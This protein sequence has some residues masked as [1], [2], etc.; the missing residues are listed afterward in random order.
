MNLELQY[1]R[2]HICSIALQAVWMRMTKDIPHHRKGEPVPAALFEKHIRPDQPAINRIIDASLSFLATVTTF[3]NDGSMPYLPAHSYFRI[4][5]VSY[6]LMKVF[7]L[8]LSSKDARQ[9]LILIKQVAEALQLH[10]PDDTHVSTHIG[11]IL[12]TLAARVP[13]SLT[14]IRLDR[15]SSNGDTSNHNGLKDFANAQ[16]TYVSDQQ[17]AALGQFGMVQ[18]H[19]GFD[20]RPSRPS[21]YPLPT[22][23]HSRGQRQQDQYA[24]EAYVRRLCQKTPSGTDDVLGPARQMGYGVSSPTLSALPPRSLYASAEEAANQFPIPQSSFWTPELSHGTFEMMPEDD[25]ALPPLDEE[26]PSLVAMP[27]NETPDFG[28][29]NGYAQH[30]W[31]HNDYLGHAPMSMMANAAEYGFGHSPTDQ[32]HYGFQSPIPFPPPPGPAPQ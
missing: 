21:V 10:A 14:N 5:F 22:Q 1:Y 15:G 28:L 7:Y 9:A 23:G 16:Q 2:V 27:W 24:R 17:S 32:W 11:G 20:R 29:N 3:A 19:Q 13:P 26:Q 31:M 25:N 8:G 4:I 30:L 12:K 18:T 6:T